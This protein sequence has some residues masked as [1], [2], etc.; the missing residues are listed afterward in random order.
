MADEALQLEA[1]TNSAD[2]ALTSKWARLSFSDIELLI[3][4]HAANKTQTEIASILG[5]SQGTVS[6]TLAK[7]Q[8]T[9]ATVQ[10]LMKTDSV[11]AV[12]DWRRA[13]K[14]A[15]KRGDHRPAREWIEEAHPDMRPQAANSAGGGGVV[16][17]I[18]MPGQPIA[19]PTIDV[20][21]VDSTPLSPVQIETS[22]EGASEH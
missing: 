3:R 22:S 16:I 11:S 21:V 18:G 17:N 6:T 19:L 12:H 8:S 9:P 1:G 4:L 15:A 20:Q 13:R 14:V 7:L 10:A 5:C 2:T